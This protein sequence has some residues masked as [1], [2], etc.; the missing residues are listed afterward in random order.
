MRK[1]HLFIL[2]ANIVPW[3]QCKNHSYPGQQHL[4]ISMFCLCKNK[5]NLG[6]G[7]VSSSKTSDSL[8]KWRPCQVQ[9]WLLLPSGIICSLCAELESACS[10]MDLCSFHINGRIRRKILVSKS[11][12]HTFPLWCVIL[13]HINIHWQQVSDTSQFLGFNARLYL[14]VMKTWLNNMQEILLME[15]GIEK[16]KSKHFFAWKTL[17]WSILSWALGNAFPLFTLATV[18]QLM[19]IFLTVFMLYSLFRYVVP[20]HLHTL[21]RGKA[22]ICEP[23]YQP[24]EKQGLFSHLGDVRTT[25][26]R[27][28]VPKG[29][30]E[31]AL[32]QSTGILVSFHSCTSMN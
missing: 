14:D 10:W 22:E 3:F 29:R 11:I 27:N 2:R 7:S 17:K 15:I 21:V 6:C 4:G 19:V 18:W 5:I 8:P 1:C 13:H 24:C 31:S 23:S 28:S 9:N 20:W 30:G 25:D 26:H 12:L 32:A 16:R